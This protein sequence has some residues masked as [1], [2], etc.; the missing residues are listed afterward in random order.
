MKQLIQLLFLAIFV[1]ALIF[2]VAGSASGQWVQT[3]SP[4]T[5]WTYCLA[6]NGANLFAGGDGGV[7]LSTDSGASWTASDSGLTNT[8]IHSLA[9]SGSNIYAGTAYG[10]VFLSTNNGSSWALVNSGLTSNAIISNITV[11]GAYLFAGTEGSGVFRSTNNGT[12]WNVIDSGLTDSVVWTLGMSGMNL[13]A[14]TQTKMFLSTDSGVSWTPV[15]SGLS[16]SSSDFAEIGTNVYAG[17]ENGDIYRSTNNGASWK[18]LR[19]QRTALSGSVFA[20]MAYG[21]NL[22]AGTGN[23]SVYL[24]TDN[25]ITWTSVSS[26]LSGTAVYALAV[27]GNNIFAGTEGYGVFRRPLS[28]I[29]GSS[30]VTTAPQ[31]SE[32]LNIYPNPVSHEATIS[33]SADVS[34]PANV[35]IYN[36]LGSEVARLY[37]G[38]LDAGNHSLTWD[39][40]TTISGAYMCIVRMNGQVLRVP[41]VVAK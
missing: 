5:T 38:T 18:A 23:D 8:E 29:L 19:L 41:V 22:F 1:S 32:T 39:A 26:G 9:M 17:D 31:Q 28:E 10:G 11:N 7:F 13:I 36:F 37:D 21:S 15:D 12:S 4:Y 35:S 25:G 33:F 40:S 3:S 6:S 2:G 24:S 16:G 34:S 30:S 14:G 27:S 20:L